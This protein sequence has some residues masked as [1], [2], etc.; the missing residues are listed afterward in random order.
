[1]GCVGLVFVAIVC[2][3]ETLIMVANNYSSTHENVDVKVIQDGCSTEISGT[4]DP[5]MPWA[6][7]VWRESRSIFQ[8]H[9]KS[10]KTIREFTV[11]YSGYKPGS[12]YD[13]LDYN[14][15]SIKDYHIVKPGETLR[16]CME[17]WS[18]PSKDIIHVHLDNVEFYNSESDI[19]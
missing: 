3:M 13:Y 6:T 12:S 11:S 4:P 16:L 15:K 5:S 18:I 8:I 14:Y 17:N 1:M 9:N 10:D 2:L 19:P 7:P